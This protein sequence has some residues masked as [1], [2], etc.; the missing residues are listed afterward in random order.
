MDPA[1]AAGLALAVWQV[2]CR[3]IEVCHNYAAAVKGAG[4]QQRKVQRAAQNLR[5]VLEALRELLSEEDSGVSNSTMGLAGFMEGPLNECREELERLLKRL[6]PP[7]WT[8]K[9]R[10]GAAVEAL[11]WPFDE[12][13]TKKAIARLEHFK[14]T[15][16]LALS[17]DQR[18]LQQ[19]T[20]KTIEI[21][22]ES[23]S[24]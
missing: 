21:V 9:G 5:N 6:E 19:A 17:I 7:S 24:I 22:K 1:T 3:I 14:S 12:G 13:D 2:S 11:K 4:S 20:Q 10:L 16:G 8:G 18:R 15:L 23:K